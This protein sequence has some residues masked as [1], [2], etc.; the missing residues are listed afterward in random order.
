MNPFFQNGCVW[1]SDGDQ[2][3]IMSDPLQPSNSS[4]L[5]VILISRVILHRAPD[6][7]ITAVDWLKL[8]SPENMVM[9]AG[10][11]RYKSGILYCSQGNLCPELG[12]LSYMRLGRPPTSIL[13]GY[14]GTPFNSIQNV[15]EDLDGGLWFTDSDMGFERSI[16]PKPQLPN[17]VY[18]FDPK[19]NDLRVVADGFKKPAGI[20]I[21]PNNDTLYITDIDAARPDGTTDR[22]RCVAYL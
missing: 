9:P 16:R 20:A 1:V 21:S 2:L 12:G 22:T 17:Q 6:D 8:R 14:F 11:C 7:S 13:Y 19:T 15:I 18:R 4:Q 10:A 5:P 3:Y